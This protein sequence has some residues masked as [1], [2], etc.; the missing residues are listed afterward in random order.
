MFKY[1]KDDDNI[2][3]NEMDEEEAWEVISQLENTNR[4]VEFETGSK[5]VAAEKLCQ[6]KHWFPQR[7]QT[8]LKRWLNA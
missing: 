7:L 8:K 3:H 5:C 1:Y 2:Y 6:L 4:I